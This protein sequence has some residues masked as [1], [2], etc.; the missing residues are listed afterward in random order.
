MARVRSVDFLPQIFQT[1]TNKQFLSATLD[2]LTQEPQ[3]KKTQGYIG[4]TVGPGVDPNDVYVVE[5]NKT[6]ADYQLEPGVVALVPDTNDIKQLMTYPGL[7]DAIDFQGGNGARSDRLYQSQYYSW[8]P[9]VEFDT[10]VNFN[11]YYWWPNGPAVVD[12][13]ST[14]IPATEQFTVTRGGGAYT[15]SGKAGNNPIITLVRGGSYTFSVAQNRVETE[16]FR[17]QNQGQAAYLI[18]RQPNPA[19]TLV[20]GNTYVFA[21]NLREDFPFWIKT[22]PSLGTADAYNNGVSRNGSLTGAVTFTVPRDAP[23]TLYYTSENNISLQ[24]TLNIVDGTPGTGSGFWI[25]TNPGVSGKVF[26]YENISSRDVMGVSNN[27]VDLG[28]IVFNV[29]RA[30]DQE[31]FYNLPTLAFPVDLITDLR[32]DDINN[33]PLLDFI[34]QYGG[35]DG[36]TNLDGR[37]LVFTTSAV[38]PQAGGWFRTTRYDPLNPGEANNS[39]PGSYD[40][41]PFDLTTEIPVED[42]RQLWQI[43]IETSNN[44]PY[45]QLERIT[46]IP[47]NYK[48]NIRFGTQYSNT[49]WYKTAQNQFSRVPLLSAASDVLYY[50]DGT[51]PEIFGEIRLVDN[52]QNNTIFID[53]ILGQTQYTSPNGVK[54]TNGLK[55]HFLGDVVPASYASGTVNLVCTSTTAGINAITTYDTSMLYTNQQ[56]VFTQPTIGGLQPGITYYVA[57]IINELQFTVSTVPNGPDVVLETGSV[58]AMNATAI[59]NREFYV[60]GVGTAIQLLPTTDFVTPEEYVIVEDPDGSTLTTQPNEPDYITIDRSSQDL[61]A[62]SRSNRWFHKDVLVATATYNNLEI[63]LPNDFRGRRPILQFRPN[64]RLYNMGTRGKQPV[65]VI[66]FEQTDAF[67]DIE[68][69]LGYST[70]GYALE[71]G[72]RVVFAADIDPDVRNKIY[73]VEFISPDSLPDLIAQPIIHLRLA[74]DGVVLQDD[75]TVCLDGDT[76]KGVTFWYNGDQWI[77]AQQK[78]NI[79]QPPLYNVYDSNG[80]SFGDATTYPST[81]FVGS[82]LFSYGL[83]TSSAVD[84]VLNLPLRYQNIA[85]IGDIVFENNLYRDS[86]IYTLNRV[87]QTVPVSQGFVREYST[88][89]DFRRR[90]GWQTAVTDTKVYQQFK[91]VYNN[92]DPVLDVRVQ[93]Q[94]VIPS[95]KIYIENIFVDPNRYSYTRTGNTTTVTFSEAPPTG[96][97][98]EILALSEQTSSVA[99]RQVPINLQNNPF[100][101]NSESFTL[102]TIRQHYDNLCENIIDFQGQIN[103]ANN[104]RDLGNIVPYGVTIVQ[105]SAPLTLTGYFLRD[106]GY[107]FFESLIFNSREYLK[108]KNLVLDNVTQQE[109]QFQSAAQILDKAIENITAGRISNQPFYWSDML[110]SGVVYTQTT[111]TVTNTSTNTFDTQQVYDYDSANYR[112]FNVYFQDQILLRGEDYVVSTDTP[113]FTILFPLAVGD[114]IVIRE[115][116][117]TYGSYCPNTPTKLGLY[118]SWRPDYIEVRASQGTRTVIR[119]HDG[120]LTPLFGDIRDEVLLEFE[121]RIYNNLKLDGNPVPLMATDVIPGQFRDTG[122]SFAEVSNILNQDFLSYVAWN[123]LDYRSQDYRADNEFTWNYSTATNRLDGENLLGAWRGIYRYFYD[124]EQPESTPWEMLGLTVKPDWWDNNYGAAPYTNN[125][126]VMWDDLAAGIVRDPAGSYVA[127]AYVRPRLTEVIPTGDQGQ[128]LSP[129]DSVVGNYDSNQFRRSWSLNDGSPVQAS[130]YNSSAYPFAVMRLLALTRPAKF[131]ALFAD[132]DLYRYDSDLQQYLL[133]QRYRLD[134]Q[135]VQV[136]G[137]GVSKASY[138]NWIVDYN[139]QTGINSTQTLETDLAN[140]DVRLCY[141]MASFS[142][143]GLIQLYTDRATPAGTNTGLL[144]PDQ[145]YNLLLY[146][147]QPFGRAVYSSVLVQN[148]PGGYAV[149]GYS[150]T[151]PFFNI[152]NSFTSGQLQTLTVGSVSVR[153]PTD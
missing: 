152:Q 46:N 3:F 15:F 137:D 38:S 45:I 78:T 93:D 24:G 74:S 47:E 55:I 43:T 17:V 14:T 83:S 66:D 80:V 110:P 81:N 97:L 123:K 12:V 67:S 91:F 30:A 56:I 89:T 28:Q 35:I 72:S 100:N 103:G 106:P 121:R 20:R 142:D 113:T 119:G 8:D 124:T 90:L 85:N 98:I 39:L 36:I 40:S 71:N 32:F 134:A 117:N 135:G 7:A 84:P 61:N 48:F 59:N 114:Q 34:E 148:V 5:P 33:Q 68:G 65:N 79:Q 109:L 112:G 122:Y 69:S 82:K 10:L 23:D 128:L 133:N 127:T 129:F 132:R 73:V 130:W 86:F 138:I 125:N 44:L 141:R 22:L 120:S 64:I 42:R 37:T 143:K 2:I 92:Q 101:K 26:G 151:Q 4:R 13:E 144:L 99:F 96:A 147:N 139:R 108:Y 19:L 116:Q 54:F 16:N 146:K 88:R 31:F 115:Y 53:Q 118:P 52:A 105:Q 25:Q 60:S 136:Y 41:I 27:G 104:S 140:L 29:P 102:G 51:D 63:T 9:F 50:Q 150:T 70:D 11:Q 62:W 153:V 111:Y 131:F 77:R 58:A 149:F 75:S 57:T 6:R 87:S 18:D 49:T 126:L 21:L 1:D 76:L 145:S 95:I 107:S 94:S